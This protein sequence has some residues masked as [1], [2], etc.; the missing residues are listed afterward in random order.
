MH[1]KAPNLTMTQGSALFRR[2]MQRLVASNARYLSTEPDSVDEYVHE[3]GLRPFHR[4]STDLIYSRADAKEVIGMAKALGV[5]DIKVITTTTPKADRSLLH[6]IL[7]MVQTRLRIDETDETLR[8]LINHEKSQ[9]IHSAIKEP[10]DD[11]VR[12]GKLDE[13]PYTFDERLN[14][15]NGFIS[16]ITSSQKDRP[17]NLEA[18]NEQWQI[19]PSRP[20]YQNKSIET[21]KRVRDRIEQGTFSPQD[22]EDAG[23]ITRR[24]M[25]HTETY[26][27]LRRIGV[28]LT[29]S[30]INSQI[31]EHERLTLHSCDQRI[32][33]IIFGGMGAGKS[34]FLSSAHYPDV[35]HQNADYLKTALW[36][37]AT[38]EGKLDSQY[39]LEA[40]QNES[41][42]VAYESRLTR[43]HDARSRWVGPNVIIGSLGLNRPEID[44]FLNSGKE[45]KADHVSMDVDKAVKGCYERALRI[46]RKPNEPAIRKSYEDSARSILNITEHNGKNIEV[47]IYER[48]DGNPELNARIDCT[49]SLVDVFDKEAFLRTISRSNLGKTPEES[50]AIF[51][52]KFKQAGFA[53]NYKQGQLS[54]PFDEN[55]LNGSKRNNAIVISTQ[56]DKNTQSSFER[57]SSALSITNVGQYK[58]ANVKAYLFDGDVSEGRLGAVIDCKECKI[59]VHDQ[60]AFTDILATSDLNP[61][62]KEES[63][64]MLLNK[65]KKDGFEIVDKE[66]QTSYSQM[67]RN[68]QRDLVI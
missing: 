62:N 5:S 8:G 67:V 18:F 3:E 31:P 43:C 42:I 58:G 7:N 25:G 33:H 23:D 32:G 45:I 55:S 24:I 56:A 16:Q 52:D 9:Q 66:K 1:S 20:R 14:I 54:Q 6:S 30:H 2:S 15:T 38:E 41:S 40:T 57:S 65:L 49:R 12:K 48:R 44:E 4:A 10:F 36:T 60:K 27:Q 50:S 39:G 61:K 21:Y 53:V 19:S 26:K 59:N 63:A 11:A 17:W 51:I 29:D 34:Y 35:S 22:G 28:T 68:S 37:T 64:N 13:M 47:N 46:G